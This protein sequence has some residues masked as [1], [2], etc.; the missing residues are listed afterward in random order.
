MN[1][2][3]QS[4]SLKYRTGSGSYYTETRTYN[5]TQLTGIQGK[6][7]INRLAACAEALL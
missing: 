2:S 4:D 1:L 3:D 6:R 7:L 5:N